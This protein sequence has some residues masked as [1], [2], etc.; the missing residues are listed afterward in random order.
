MIYPDTDPYPA[1]I[2]T[3]REKEKMLSAVIIQGKI[4]I[5]EFVIRNCIVPTI[6]SVLSVIQTVCL[7]ILGY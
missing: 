3:E 5:T 4:Y 1:Y 7:V 6:S 2:R